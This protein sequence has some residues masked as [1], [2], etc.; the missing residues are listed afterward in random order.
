MHRLLERK[1]RIA[2]KAAE[3][4]EEEDQV[5]DISTERA[6]EEVNF[7]LYLQ[8]L[9][10]YQWP[11]IQMAARKR[12][13]RI[14]A[15]KKD[16]VVELVISEWIR[17]GQTPGREAEGLLSCRNRRKQRHKLR[18]QL[19]LRNDLRNESQMKD[20]LQQAKGTLWHKP[21]GVRE[22]NNDAGLPGHTSH[23]WRCQTQPG[24]KAS[25]T[26]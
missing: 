6:S 7:A 19:T 1:K 10:N 18:S 8:G 11:L 12:F 15:S 5:E 26:W 3:G 16:L 9:A 24:C 22:P 14:F 21:C 4:V 13:G 25:R 17:Q 23:A 20:L 2:T